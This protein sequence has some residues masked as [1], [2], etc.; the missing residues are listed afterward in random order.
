MNAVIFAKKGY[1]ITWNR[2][3]VFFHISLH[4][5]SPKCKLYLTL[6]MEGKVS[7]VAFCRILLPDSFAG[8]PFTQP[9]KAKVTVLNFRSFATS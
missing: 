7:F 1:C 9:F 6:L 3:A 2:L 4:Y 5:Y 8:S